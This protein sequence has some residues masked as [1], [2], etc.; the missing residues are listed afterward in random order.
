MTFV[1]QPSNAACSAS[2]SLASNESAACKYIGF[3]SPPPARKL[4]TTFF[5]SASGR[6]MVMR[7]SAQLPTHSAL[8]ALTA[9]PMSSGARSGKL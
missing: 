4:S 8:L 3:P 6:A 1:R 5:S 7:P 9:A 2:R